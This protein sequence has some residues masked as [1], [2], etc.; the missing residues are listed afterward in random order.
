MSG[1]GHSAEKSRAARGRLP[2]A[3]AAGGLLVALT[4]GTWFLLR[5]SEQAFD[6]QLREAL[7][8]LDRPDDP[9]AWE[10]ARRAAERVREAGFRDPDF[11]GAAEYVLGI[12]ASRAP[13]DEGVAVRASA[14]EFLREAERQG[15]DEDRRDEWSFALGTAL[16]A[17][18]FHEAARPLLED[19]WWKFE[20]GKVASGLALAEIQLARPEIGATITADQVVAE[21]GRRKDLNAGDRRRLRVIRTRTAL[22]E[23]DA[24]EAAAALAEL[25]SGDGPGG[26]VGLLR[27]EIFVA[28]GR[29]DEAKAR[30]LE[31]TGP[32]AAEA[33]PERIA[34]ALH[35]LG[36]CEERRGDP[37][38]AERAFERAADLA[39][40]SADGVR[41]ALMAARLLQQAGRDEEAFAL[42]RR[43]AES[44]AAG[45]P[46]PVPVEEVRQA[47]RAGWDAWASRGAF[48]R[49]VALAA[50]AE[51]VLGHVESARLRAQGHERAAAE[52]EAGGAA[53]PGVEAGDG[54]ERRERWRQSG[55][56]YRDLAAAVTDSKEIGEALWTSA[57]HFGRGRAFDEAEAVLTDLLDLRLPRLEAAV[58][59]RRG[60]VR[61]DLNRPEQAAEDFRA[62][63]DRHPTDPEAF[64][65]RYELGRC[66]LERGDSA[67]AEAAWREL[68]SLQEL[69]PDAAEWRL[70]L[71]ALAELLHRRG[72]AGLARVER[73]SAD[74]GRG[75]A[76]PTA[77]PGEPAAA[78]AAA[79]AA[80]DEAVARF[81]EY[82]RRAGET[83]RGVEARVLRADAMRR[84]A[85]VSRGRAAAAETESLREVHLREADRLLAGAIAELRAVQATLGP[86]DDAGRLS[87]LERELLKAT[88]FDIGQAHAAAGRHQ[89]AVTAYGAAV[90]RYPE[91]ARVLPA[92]LRMAECYRALGRADDARAAVEQA[93]IVLGQMAPTALDGESVLGRDEWEKW[94]GRAKSVDTPVP[95]ASAAK[96]I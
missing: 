42:F 79:V 40:E 33:D 72:A 89:E 43:A 69:T 92:Y 5:P 62:I 59:A 80:L 74:G 32:E 77:V 81:D 27:A 29:L 87:R 71:F 31:L 78:E 84:R 2:L 49:A 47:I 9:D 75:G 36:R 67:A 86:F 22:H 17:T 25:E 4:G 1:H 57:E 68:L 52:S 14:V 23:G 21:L 76:E 83:E 20:S 45:E 50:T 82:V 48:D 19:A 85:E 41:G 91:D 6:S 12:V 51:P 65:A 70:A 28:E 16:F 3:V 66:H 94:L 30:L 24:K 90:N 63:L 88:A 39:P 60:R 13:A 11:P 10:S 7:A 73:G 53:V 15:L 18:G 26:D 96:E 93:R 8:K 64:E 38:A 95:A 54:S 44:E 58:L 61:L 56:A 55:A 34:A 37:G 35:L 46:A